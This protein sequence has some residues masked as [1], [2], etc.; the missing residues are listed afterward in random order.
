MGTVSFDPY[1]ERLRQLFVCESVRGCGLGSVLVG[2][3]M[4][5][6]EGDVLTV[7]AWR[8]SEGFYLKCGFERCGGVYLDNGDECQVMIKRKD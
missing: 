4:S 2:E 5:C 3:C 8:R 6:V 1:E 7:R